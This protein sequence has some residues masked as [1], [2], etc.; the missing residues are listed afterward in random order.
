MI[1]GLK[2]DELE[3]V[4]E[5]EVNRLRMRIYPPHTIVFAKSGMSCTK[6]L[7]YEIRR[8]SVVV[9]HLAAI[10]CG[11]ELHSRFLLRWY[12]A[13]PPTRLIVNPSYPSIKISDIRNEN[14]PLPPLAEQKRIASI[15]DAADAL[16]AKCRGGGGGGGPRPA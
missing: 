10:E 16:R 4:R 13:N 14:I 5:E 2:E 3:L 7:I 1:E 11:S 6:G 15:L 9:N 12:Q 8:P